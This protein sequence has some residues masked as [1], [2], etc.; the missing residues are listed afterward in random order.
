MKYTQTF[1]AFTNTEVSEKI[2]NPKGTPVFNTLVKSLQDAVQKA[3]AVYED[4]Q[5]NPGSYEGSE[6]I[7]VSVLLNQV[8]A[9]LSTGNENDSSHNDEIFK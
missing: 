6:A 1:E 7:D 2:H 4:G 9:A 8:W 3:K 5:D